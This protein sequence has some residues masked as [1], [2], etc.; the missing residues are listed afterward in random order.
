MAP[1]ITRALATDV[2]I[3]GQAIEVPDTGLL[4]AEVST[5]LSDILQPRKA[6][7]IAIVWSPESAMLGADSEAPALFQ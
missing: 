6:T 7:M 5:G 2:V 4:L 1:A 3:V